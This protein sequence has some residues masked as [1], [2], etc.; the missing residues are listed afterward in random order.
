MNGDQWFTV[1]KWLV[2]L[3][4]ETIQQSPE[5]LLTQAWVLNHRFRLL[6]IPEILER[7]ETILQN[8]PSKQALTGELCFFKAFLSFWQGQLDSSI[9]YSGKSQEQV[10]KEKKG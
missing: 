7:V 9:A 10:P 1:E 4:I 2:Q 6:E 3:P 5:L 8:D